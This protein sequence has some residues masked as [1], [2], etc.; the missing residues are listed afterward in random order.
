MNGQTALNANGL[1]SRI[2]KVVC[3]DCLFECVS[4]AHMHICSAEKA[5]L[6]L[7]KLV[8]G[9]MCIYSVVG[10]RETEI[11][12]FFKPWICLFSNWF[13]PKL[14]VETFFNSSC[15]VNQGKW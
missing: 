11:L 6:H 7:A 8:L 1:L 12:I 14:L 5:C 4:R 15:K 9:G 10:S 3:T 13:R 2:T